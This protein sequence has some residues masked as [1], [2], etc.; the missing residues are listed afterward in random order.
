MKQMFTLSKLFF[1]TILLLAVNGQLFAQTEMFENNPN[2]TAAPAGFGF[3]GTNGFITGSTGTNDRPASV[4]YGLSGGTAY[5]ASNTSRTLTS[6]NISTLGTN[7]AAL[8]FRLQAIS[9]NST[10]NGMETSDFVRVEISPNGGTTWY[11][12]LEV[13]GSSAGQAYWGYS[14]T[15][16][17][18]ANYD[19]NTSPTTYSPTGSGNI[20]A[21][22]S[23]VVVRGLP[24]GITNLRV[25]ITM[26]CSSGN[27]RWV[28]DAVMLM[29]TSGGPLPVTFANVSAKE[30]NGKV[31]INWS[32]LTESEINY[33]EVE[34]SSD[35]VNFTTIAKVS[36][37]ANNF[38]SQ[39]Y[40]F[41]DAN[42]NTVNFYRIKAVEF[43][44]T[45][46]TTVILKVSTV[47]AGNAFQV[48]PNPVKN[49]VVTIQTSNIQGG[50]YSAQVLSTNGQ[51]MM[52]KNITFQSGSASQ[53]FELSGNIRPGTYLLKIENGTTKSITTLFV[54]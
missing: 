39:D 36:P 51:V 6:A 16:T 41:T 54:Q 53:S 18:N 43:A 1:V 8:T 27:E 38:S 52:S 37:K 9:E 23:T 47:K 34:R 7:Y 17:A 24:I 48:Y 15:G 32:N 14:A 5:Q 31:G 25:R 33:Y 10:S 2:F 50:I 49:K 42:P 28:I 4:T 26:D 20:A 46:K 45:S 30:T 40:S 35:A 22:P 21:G 44:G 29:K 11:N 3:T 19:G 12:T 13:T